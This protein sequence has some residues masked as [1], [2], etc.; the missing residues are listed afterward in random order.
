MP[1]HANKAWVDKVKLFRRPH[2]MQTMFQTILNW[3]M[4]PLDLLDA[5]NFVSEVRV[6]FALVEYNQHAHT[7]TRTHAHAHTHTHTHT[8]SHTRTHTRTHAV[9]QMTR[10][11]VTDIM[12]KEIDGLRRLD[13]D[14]RRRIQQWGG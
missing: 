10:G 9:A 8:H 13:R 14:L 5:Q 3:N 2:H 1:E 11:A 6:L 12:A 7:H 4:T